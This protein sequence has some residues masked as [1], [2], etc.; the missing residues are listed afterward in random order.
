ML[1]MVLAG[2]LVCVAALDAQRPEFSLRD[3]RG[4][5]HSPEEWNGKK[6]IVVFFT[7][8][9][10]PLSNNDV[11][12]MNRTRQD[13]QARG[14]AFYAVQADTTI[15]DADVLQHTR[16]Y[17]FSFPVLFDPQ[18]ILVKTT[19]ATTIPSAAVL[20]P[21]GTLLY[22]GRID[23]RV[24]DFNVRR[25]EPTKFDLREALDAVLDGKRV[26]RPRTSAFGCAIALEKIKGVN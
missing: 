4:V 19:G 5:L 12:E 20:A 3:T 1:R 6:A 10:C 24:E 14:V 22:L 8:T 26:P 18:Q 25:Q 7:T 2:A 15:A 13:Y 9:D 11:P 16:D 23:N 21:D 17:Q